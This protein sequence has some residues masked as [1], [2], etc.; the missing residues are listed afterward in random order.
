MFCRDTRG[1]IAALDGFFDDPLIGMQDEEAADIECAEAACEFIVEICRG[2]AWEGADLFDG[3]D[4]HFD[5]ALGFGLFEAH[6]EVADFGW[7]ARE[8]GSFE[9]G[10]DR[11]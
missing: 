4:G 10:L 3:G 2:V 1:R 11:L 9:C 8:V 6:E 7:S 5:V